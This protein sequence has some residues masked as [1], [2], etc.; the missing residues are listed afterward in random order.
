MRNEQ[1]RDPGNLGARLFSRQTTVL[2]HVRTRIELVE[3]IVFVGSGSGR[4]RQ[5]ARNS[6]ESQRLSILIHYAT[7]APFAI[8][9]LEAALAMEETNI[10]IW[11]NPITLRNC[12]SATRRP[13]P[14][15][16]SI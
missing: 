9:F 3:A 12:R 10:G 4:C 13:E 8:G 2:K 7:A 14:T 11:R 15:H 16:R 5:I 1:R 6:V